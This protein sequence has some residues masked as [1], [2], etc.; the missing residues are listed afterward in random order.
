VA[1]YAEEA[2]ER[3]AGFEH[4]PGDIVISTRSKCGTTWLQMIC[5]LLVFQDPELPAPLAALSPWLDWDIEPVEV[6]F[7]R[8]DRQEHRRFIKTHTPLA[9]LPLS[10]DVTYLVAGRHPLDVATSLYAHGHN[11]DRDRFEALT[12]RRSNPPTGSF[13]DWFAWWLDPGVGP[14]EVLDSLPGLVHHVT[15]AWDRQGELDVVLVHYDDLA[16]DLDGQMRRL[17]DHLGIA[18][19]EDR[20]PALVE[21]AGFDAMRGRAAERAPDHLGVLKSPDAFFRAAARDRGG[22]QLDHEAKHQALDRVHE[23]APPAVAT[24]LL[25]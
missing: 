3:W 1:R 17:A 18:V 25:R 9:G 15:D 22:D 5:A 20:W 8:L 21:A 7:A 14:S 10:P 23:L 13:A 2:N 11:I 24:W 16:D 4:R 19:A 12:G 6:V